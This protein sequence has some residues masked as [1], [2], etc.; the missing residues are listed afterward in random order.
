M[1]PVRFE[2]KRR[3]F[4]QKHGKDAGLKMYNDWVKSFEKKKPKK[5]TKSKGTKTAS[6]T[7]KMSG[8]LFF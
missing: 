5:V 1:S 6:K 8:F 7:F 4:I 2:R 3:F